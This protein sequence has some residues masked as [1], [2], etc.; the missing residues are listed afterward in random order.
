VTALRANRACR[1]IATALTLAVSA[2]ASPPPAATTPDPDAIFAAA[3]KAWG[4]GAY[5]RYATY[6]AVVSFH[7]GAKFVRRTWETTEDI[8]HGVVYSQAFS[9]EERAHPTTPHGIAFT[10]C[11][12][13]EINKQQPVDPIGHIAF[14]IDQDD[15][16]APNSRHPTSTNS[17]STLDKQSSSLPV[18]GHTGT[19]VR[20]YQVSLIETVTDQVGPEY[21][22]RLT[23]MHDPE[24]LRLRELWVDGTTWLPEESVVAGIGN[25]PPLTKIS[26]RVEYLQTRGATYIARETA[27]GDVDYGKAGTLHD[28]AIEFAEVEL[29]S[30]LSPY[31]FG[32]SKSPAQGEP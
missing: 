28:V 30:S 15:G 8:R 7:K 13:G 10:L 4:A 25:H 17:L 12:F 21:H 27:L 16:L 20:D 3:R 11:F 19:V 9:R 2:A 5:P 32:F 24:R 22:L 18:I 31:R 29:R 23:P 14:A 6:V 26:W 1:L